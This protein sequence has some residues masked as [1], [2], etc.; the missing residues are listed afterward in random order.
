MYLY[1]GFIL[2]SISRK[3]IQ[4]KKKHPAFENGSLKFSLGMLLV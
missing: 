3:I 4:K 2:L 1:C